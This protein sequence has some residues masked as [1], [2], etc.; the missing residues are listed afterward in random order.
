M[1]TTVTALTTEV[2]PP[3]RIKSFSGFI[4]TLRNAGLV[5]ESWQDAVALAIWSGQFVAEWKGEP[6]TA[7]KALSLPDN[8]E[9]FD[10]GVTVLYGERFLPSFWPERWEGGIDHRPMGCGDTSIW[11][12]CDDTTKVT[13]DQPSITSNQPFQIYA[14]DTCST[15]GTPLEERKQRAYENLV[16]H[17]SNTIGDE[18]WTGAKGIAAGYS[19]LSLVN[20]ATDLNSGSGVVSPTTLALGALQEALAQGLGD[21][22]AGLIHATRRTVSK[23]YQLGAL[24]YERN[25][26]L[27]FWTGDG[28]LVDEFGNIIVSS[29]GYDGSE[30]TGENPATAETPWAYATGPVVVRLGGVDYV[31]ADW[32]GAAPALTRDNDATIFAERA[33]TYELD[34]C[35]V[36][37]VQVS[38]CVDTC[39][40]AS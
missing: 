21:G 5:S 7:E 6:L 17:E 2:A 40:E 13:Q 15:W 26:D 10:R 3:P 4:P 25:L 31:P 16:R 18:F 9:A 35:S 27:D 24:W 12:P 37:G 36:Y 34:P 19:N 22:Q 29:G 11:A 38:L 30:I 20:D 28:Y 8:H 1:S 39:A 32:A 14:D 33:V 23:W